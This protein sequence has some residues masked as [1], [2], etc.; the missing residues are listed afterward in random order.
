MYYIVSN[1]TV[2]RRIVKIV[3]GRR[4]KRNSN[5]NRDIL[6]A[7]REHPLLFLFSPSFRGNR[8]AHHKRAYNDRV[9]LSPKKIQEDGSIVT[10]DYRVVTVKLSE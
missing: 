2:P 8:Y 9:R 10:L 3:K 6:S 7:S 1:F 4:V 5:K